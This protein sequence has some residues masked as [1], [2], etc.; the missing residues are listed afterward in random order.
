MTGWLFFS[1]FL[2]GCR[3]ADGSTPHQVAFSHQT[4][5]S[6]SKYLYTYNTSHLSIL[7]RRGDNKES[8]ESFRPLR[9]LSGQRSFISQDTYSI[10][11]DTC[12]APQKRRCQGCTSAPS[13]KEGSRLGCKLFPLRVKSSVS[14]FFRSTSALI[15]HWPAALHICTSWVSPLAPALA[16]PFA[17]AP[18]TRPN[19]PG[20]PP[21]HRHTHL[22]YSGLSTTSLSLALVGSSPFA[23]TQGAPTFFYCQG[24]LHPW[25]QVLCR[26]TS[27]RSRQTTPRVAVVPIPNILAANSRV[28]RRKSHRICRRAS[29][30]AT[31]SSPHAIRSSCAAASVK[32]VILFIPSGRTGDTL[33]ILTSRPGWQPQCG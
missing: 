5:F 30:P 23:Y 11:Q 17:P 19:S 14:S 26:P 18:Q 3:S 8:A 12:W 6:S 16:V 9:A 4:S 1:F 31:S 27:S 25:L 15:G 24:V 21:I 33:A 28:F 2:K 29:S 13:L 20:L 7:D 10:H 22:G 32:R